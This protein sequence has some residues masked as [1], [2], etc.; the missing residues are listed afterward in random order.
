MNKY[1]IQEILD[2]DYPIGLAMM[3]HED[4]EFEEFSGHCPCGTIFGT[5]FKIDINCW[6]V[7][8]NG[9]EVKFTGDINKENKDKIF[10]HLRNSCWTDCD[11]NLIE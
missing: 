6:R 9:I 3:D 1:S 11:W 5:D 10:E 4:S 7:T 8:G 2:N